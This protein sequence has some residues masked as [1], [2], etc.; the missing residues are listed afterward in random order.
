[1]IQTKEQKRRKSEENL[2]D[3]WDTIKKVNLFTRGRPEEP[4]REEDRGLY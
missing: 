4:E 2:R 1:M 3:S